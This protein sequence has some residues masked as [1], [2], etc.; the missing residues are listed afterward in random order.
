MSKQQVQ[1]VQEVREY[2]EDRLNSIKILKGVRDSNE[3]LVF[4]ENMKLYV[5][6]SL[7][8]F[9]F[10]LWFQISDLRFFDKILENFEIFF[11]YF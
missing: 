5:F 1:E 8:V 7:I 4:I 11:G 6:I 2:N 3:L 10:V 9:L